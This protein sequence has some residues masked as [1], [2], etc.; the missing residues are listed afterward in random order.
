MNQAASS[1]RK[2]LQRYK[3]RD[4]IGRWEQ[5]KIIILSK[6]VDWLSQGYFP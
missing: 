4:F 5:N 1:N 3:A 6:N 2:V